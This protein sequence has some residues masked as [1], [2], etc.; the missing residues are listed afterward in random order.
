VAVEI[1]QEVGMYAGELLASL[2]HMFLPERIAISGGT[3]AAGD[4]LLESAQA[5]FEYLVGDY[6]RLYAAHSNGYYNG[7]E[8][9]LGEMK[10][11]TG[12]IGATLGFFNPQN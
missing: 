2:S 12:L 6:H 11:E 8:I 3:S 4:L 10:T 7:V 9:V 5:R 1:I